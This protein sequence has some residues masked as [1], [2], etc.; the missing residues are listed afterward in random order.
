M[1][2][3]IR[4][5]IVFSLILFF[6][7]SSEDDTTQTQDS[8]PAETIYFPPM[9]SDIWDTKTLT[10]I[11]YNETNLQ[12]LLDF[13]EDKN[14][15]V[16]IMLHNGKIVIEAYMNNHN[17][18]SPW[19]WASAGKTLTTAVTGIAQDEGLLDINAKV[20]DYIDTGWTSIPLEKENLIT[21]KSLLTMTSGLDDTLGDSISAENLQ[22][23]ADAGDRRAYHNVYLKL[24][25]VVAIASNQTWDSYFNTHLKNRIG[26]SGAWIPFGNLNTYWSTT[27]SMARFGLLTAAYGAWEDT[28]IISESFL[29]KA[30]N[31]SQSTNPAYGYLWWLNG[32]S[33]YQLPQSQSQISGELIPNAPDDMYCALGRN[34]QKIYIVPS[35]KLVI[36]R[37][38]ECANNLNFALSSFDN[39]LWEQL[40]LVID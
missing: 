16:F 32:K 33:S 23:S 39:D 38:G 30:T 35:E 24:Q 19:Y 21:N 17:V 18:A 31:T 15:K 7:C 14:T 37:M 1:N 26:M 22:Y 20:S 34:D 11:G 27:R 9:S 3:S 2:S 28:Q 4:A 5:V 6:N 10:E 40:N 13:L 8:S 25:D 12:P 29:T 36:I